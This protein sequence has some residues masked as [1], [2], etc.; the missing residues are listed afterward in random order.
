MALFPIPTKE[1]AE[2]VILARF[3]PYT[4]KLSREEAQ[5]FKDEMVEAAKDAITTKLDNL[6]ASF[7][8][9][10]ES[11]TA[12]NNVPVTIATGITTASTIMPPPAGLTVLTSQLMGNIPVWQAQASDADAKAKQILETLSM[13]KGTVPA[14]DTAVSVVEGIAATVT[15]VKE[16][17][18]AIP[19]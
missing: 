8:A 17:L 16:A 14:I 7:D 19:I 1:L 2:Q 12:L 5:K 15:T 10:S 13:F 9:L 6:N 18:G 11:L 4:D 3:K